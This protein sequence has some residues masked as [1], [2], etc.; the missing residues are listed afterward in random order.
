MRGFSV[1]ESHDAQRLPHVEEG[2][3]GRDDP[4]PV[5]D[6]WVLSSGALKTGRSWGLLLAD[7]GADEAGSDALPGLSLAQ[8]AQLIAT[9][10]K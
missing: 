6:E 2:L 9:C 3:A 1:V 4:D 10:I 8:T 7:Q 5:D